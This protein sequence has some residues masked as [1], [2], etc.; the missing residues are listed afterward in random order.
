MFGNQLNFT[1]AESK[2]FFHV[3][4]F[5][6][7]FYVRHWLEC[8]VAI[9]APAN[10]L[11]LLQALSG[12]KEPHLN[13][14]FLKLSSHL[15]YLSEKLVRFCLFDARVSLQDKGEI[16]HAMKTRDGSVGVG[17]RA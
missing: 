6:S 15:R 3:C 16:V 11:E 8:P 5:L 14:A 17:A 2:E 4:S 7:G 13:A 10:D 9:N 12:R 1:T